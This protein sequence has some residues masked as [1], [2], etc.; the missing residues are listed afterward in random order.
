MWTKKAQGAF[1]TLKEKLSKF[2]CRNPTLK[3][4]E[5]HGDLGVL[6]DSQKL[7]V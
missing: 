6:R 7:K 2:P 1:D 3:E 5:C 4:C